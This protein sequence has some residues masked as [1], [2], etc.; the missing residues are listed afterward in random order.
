[1]Q[2]METSQL[3]VTSKWSLCSPPGRPWSPFHGLGRKVMRP[4][5]AGSS[6]TR[7]WQEWDPGAPP[8]RSFKQPPGRKKAKERTGTRGYRQEAHRPVWPERGELLWLI[9]GSGLRRSE[10]RSHCVHGDNL[11]PLFLCMD[12][13]VKGRLEPGYPAVVEGK[14]LLA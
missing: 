8:G 11:F 13:F 6:K 12:Q 10:C 7:N 2:L 1:M 4:S 9:Q 14:Q 3:T 5:R